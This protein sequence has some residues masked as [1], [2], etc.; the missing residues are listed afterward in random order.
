[1]IVIGL[2]IGLPLAAYGIYDHQRHEWEMIRS[3]GVGGLFNYFGSL[4][5]AFGWIGAVMLASQ[6]DALPGL[7]RR[8]GAV[9]QMAF[10]NYIM[11]SVVC[12]LIYNGHGLGLF[13]YVDRIWQQLLCLGIF[14]FQLWYSPLW[15]DRFR[16]G[17]L[18]WMWRSLTYWQV[19]PFRREPEATIGN[20]TVER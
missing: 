12:T 16:F 5:A 18:E 9:G 1:M 14:S 11:H 10:T 4:F 20:P 15:L 17:P 13:G 7:R 3:M 8:L 6:V 2:G 19:Q